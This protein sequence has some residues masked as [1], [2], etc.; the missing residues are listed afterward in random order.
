[1]KKTLLISLFA[2]VA[3]CRPASVIPEP[4]TGPVDPENPQPPEMEQTVSI[5]FLKTLYKGAPVRITGEY[6]I[7]GAVVSNDRDGNFY[8]TLVVDDGTSGIEMKLDMEDIF[9]TYWIHGRVTVRCNGLWLGSYGG[10][11]QLGSAPFGGY[12]TQN[13]SPNE[14]AEHLF[15]DNNFYGEVIPRR[16]G[17]SELTVRDISTYVA[18][19]DVQFAD[20]E[21]GILSWAEEDADTDRHLVD[22]AGDTLTVRTS[23]HAKFAFRSLPIGNGRI[24]G[25]V[26]CFNGKYQLV[27]CHDQ[28]ARMEGTRF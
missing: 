20:E 15:P 5:A 17:F 27:V 11:L 23:C 4:G 2:L 1:M 16:L 14:I 10:T 9:L 19:T 3:A 13:I 26:S 12:E 25:V 22:A 21:A 7:E 28:N 6:L 18:F 24:E 8:K